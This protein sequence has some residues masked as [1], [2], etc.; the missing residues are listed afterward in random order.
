MNC[1]GDGF[2]TWQRC[3]GNCVCK[4]GMWL[5][6]T[7]AANGHWQAREQA[8]AH[9][10]QLQLLGDCSGVVDE[11]ASGLSCMLTSFQND[12]LSLSTICWAG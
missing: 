8:E 3:S 6:M 9:Q 2:D 12:E 11:E 5:V 1:G 7:S 10:G 4:D